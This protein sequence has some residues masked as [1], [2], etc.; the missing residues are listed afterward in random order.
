MELLKHVKTF[1][2]IINVAGYLPEINSLIRIFMIPTTSKSEYIYDK[3]FNDIQNILLENKISRKNIPDKVMVDFEKSLI[4]VIK[5][6]F[7]NSIVNGCFFHYIKLL[8]KKAKALSL[9]NK[10]I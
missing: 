2:Q 1:Y 8:W 5:K 4:N 6:N 7:P 10:D 3:I 9:C